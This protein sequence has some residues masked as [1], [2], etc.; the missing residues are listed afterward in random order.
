M[1]FKKY[2]EAYSDK[3]YCEDTIAINGT[4][5]EILSGEIIRCR[6]YNMGQQ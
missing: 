1:T 2:V 4:F 3:L 6:G 5:K